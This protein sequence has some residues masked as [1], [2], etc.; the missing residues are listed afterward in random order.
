MGHLGRQVLPGLPE[1]RFN[2]PPA[3]LLY[4]PR[5][6]TT[7]EREASFYWKLSFRL[8]KNQISKIFELLTAFLYSP[9]M[10]ATLEREAN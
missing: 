4:G 5:M 1:A 7:L 9:R 10:A 3:A 8:G 6:A 2:H